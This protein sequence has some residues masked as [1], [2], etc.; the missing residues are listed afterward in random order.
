MILKAKCRIPTQKNP[1]S[2]NHL[3]CT[4]RKCL[5]PYCEFT[6]RELNFT[7]LCPQI[8]VLCSLSHLSSL[9]FWSSPLYSCHVA[10]G[11]TRA[12][13]KPYSPFASSL[14]VVLS[15]CPV[16]WLGPYLTNGS[17]FV[18]IRDES[19]CCQLDPVHSIPAWCQG[20]FLG[21]VWC[22][23]H[24]ILWWYYFN[25]QC[26]C[27]MLRI[28]L[29]VSMAQCEFMIYICTDSKGQVLFLCW[30]QFVCSSVMFY[31]GSC[32]IMSGF[33][34]PKQACTIHNSPK[35]SCIYTVIFS[36]NP[37]SLV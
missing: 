30:N 2:G 4:W 21:L 3:H 35:P 7:A 33:T 20:L 36:L 14:V 28:I 17:P 6:K 25:R 5:T 12:N 16:F 32:Q 18:H 11:Q 13:G 23:L 15:F 22:F 9:T 8:V 10:K 26:Y 37:H 24:C 34:I 27:T 1:L 31:V 19:I 29:M